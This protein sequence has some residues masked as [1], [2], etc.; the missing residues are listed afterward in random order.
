MSAREFLGETHAFGPSST[1]VEE[2]SYP[3][4][5]LRFF[6]SFLRTSDSV[7]SFHVDFCSLQGRF[8]MYLTMRDVTPLS[9]ELAQNCVRR[10]PLDD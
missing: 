1:R 3:L 8:P 7:R 6:L 4:G 9:Y 5:A 2:A 10:A